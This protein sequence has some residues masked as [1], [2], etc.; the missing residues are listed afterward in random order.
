MPLI[1]KPIDRTPAPDPEV[2]DVLKAL[3]SDKQEVRWAAARAAAEVKGGAEALGAAVRSESDLRVREAMF[4]SLARMNSLQSVDAVVPLL[5]LDDASLR[6]GA[7][8]AL[9]AM[10]GVVR[11]RLPTLMRDSDSDVRVLTCEIV[12]SLPAEEATRLLCDLLEHETEPNVCAAVVDVLAEVGTVEAL[13]PL[14][15][16]AARFRHTPFLEFATRIAAD[17]IRAQ[18]TT[19]HG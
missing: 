16:C 14:A 10:S 15:D 12:R 11:E 8:D 1:R 13:A 17:R 7:L 19:T 3:A 9:R 4:T 6:A 2:V 18:S 5:R